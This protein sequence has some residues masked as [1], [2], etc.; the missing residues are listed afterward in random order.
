MKKQNNNFVENRNSVRIP[1]FFTTINYN[2]V[3]QKE[4]N[5]KASLYISSRTADRSSVGRN[6]AGTFSFEWSHI[7][8]EVDF[9]P[10]LVKIL[11]YLDQKIN[12]VISNQEKILKKFDKVE[13]VQDVSK[14]GE[15]IDISGSGL[16]MLITEKINPGSFL[17]LTIGPPVNPPIQIVL[18]GKLLR[19]CQ[20]RDTE[21]NGFEASITFTAINED[22][23]EDLIKYI[24][25]RQ[26]ELI[27]SKKRSEDLPSNT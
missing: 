15:C 17:E 11:F 12:K 22:D 13:E 21:I 26:R 8:D 18:L 24:F 25:K 6:D 7:E 20:S 4:Y 27:S 5:K 9:D 19:I 23:R 14:A 10:V 3:S 1:D 16:N 2:V